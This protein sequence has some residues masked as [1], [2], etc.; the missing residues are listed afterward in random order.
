V[1]A[2]ALGIFLLGAAGACA[3]CTLVND[4]DVCERPGL[5]EHEVNRR[6]EGDQFLHSP[7]ALAAMPFGGAL[8]VFVSEVSATDPDRTEVRGTVIGAE[9]T[10]LRTCDQDHELTYAA[11]DPSGPAE[12]LRLGPSVAGPAT[13][14]A[15][16]LIVYTEQQDDGRWDVL[17][18]FVSGTGCP[19]QGL[20]SFNISL[21][22]SEHLANWASVVSLG[23]NDFLVLWTTS[24]SDPASLDYRLR[25]RVVHAD[26]LGPQFLPTVR[27]AVGDPVEFVPPGSTIAYAAAVVV[28]PGRV[29]VTWL[30]NATAGPIVWAAVVDDRL[31]EVVAP[32]VVAMGHPGLPPRAGLDMA[33]D[34]EQV[35]VV[36]VARDGR[37]VPTVWGRFL[38]P[39]GDFLRAPQAPTGGAFAVGRGGGIS[40][41]RPTVASVPGGGFLVA[42]EELGAEGSDTGAIGARAFDA[43]GGARFNNRACDRDAFTLHGPL[44][45]P[46][47]LPS[48]ARLPGGSLAAAWT[49]GGFNGPDR[50]SRSIRGVVLSPRDLFPIE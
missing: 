50:S 18:R 16:G 14:D 32:F 6:T 5:P 21:G 43:Q 13:D 37:D 41:G 4:I 47:R 9:G 44:E 7:R 8:A 49:D 36:W 26:P 20:G 27:S 1:R 22:G 30:A 15:A 29:M 3:G 2:R 11:V 34:G 28:A 31:E 42:W 24:P 45:G 39:D 40:Q 10:P 33:F 35:L 23:A 25:A 48:L 12:Q 38:T 17:G 46:Q 19:Y